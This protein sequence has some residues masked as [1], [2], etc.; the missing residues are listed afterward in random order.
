MR[1]PHPRVRPPQHTE[2][3]ARFGA[4]V[5]LNVR[6]ARLGS[7]NFC[8]TSKDHHY[9]SSRFDVA[10]WNRYTYFV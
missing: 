7:E 2:E 1:R 5:P 10:G 6:K 9:L 4:A 3:F 8:S